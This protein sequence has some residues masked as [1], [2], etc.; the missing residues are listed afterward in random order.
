MQKKK[1]AGWILCN[2]VAVTP[3]WVD[4]KCAKSG[5]P[6][7]F[8]FKASNNMGWLSDYVNTGGQISIKGKQTDEDDIYEYMFASTKLQYAINKSVRR[9]IA[10]QTLSENIEPQNIVRGRSRTVSSHAAP[11]RKE[12]KGR[13]VTAIRASMKVEF[14]DEK[15]G[16]EL[17]KLGL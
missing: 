5:R 7:T 10:L 13:L 3:L 6:I 11:T 4:A 17:A 12:G 8:L 15:L 16:K 2:I 14:N 1:K 9:N